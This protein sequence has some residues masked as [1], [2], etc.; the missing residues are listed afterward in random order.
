M[1]KII[2]GIQQIGIGNTDLEKNWA[3]YRKYFGMEDF[4]CTEHIIIMGANTSIP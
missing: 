1:E 4:Y 2:S 3:W